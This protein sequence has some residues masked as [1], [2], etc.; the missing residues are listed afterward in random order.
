[1]NIRQIVCIGML[2][3]PLVVAGC[4]KGP[5]EKAGSKID[6]AMTDAGNKIEDLC[7]DAKKGLKSKD[8][9]C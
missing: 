3:L 1:M 2:G 7:E 5:A 8:P 9:N 6:S 4:E